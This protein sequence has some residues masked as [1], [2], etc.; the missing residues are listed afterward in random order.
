MIR[1]LTLIVLLGLLTP[2]LTWAS[3]RVL[4]G[5]YPFPP[6]VEGKSGVT[7]DLL[8]AM[9]SAQDKYV[10]E[11][12]ETSAN[13]RY[14]HLEEGKFQLML[15]ESIEW[16][17]DPKLVE[18]SNVFLTGDGDIYMARSA[19]GRDEAYFD[20]I[21]TRKIA[22]T[23]GY[24]YAFAN[25]QTDPE[26]LKKEFDITLVADAKQVVFLVAQ[27]VAEIGVVTK[28]YLQSYLKANPLFASSFLVSKRMDQAY[29]HAVLVKRGSRPTAQEINQILKKL[30][31]S[32]ALQKIWAKHGIVK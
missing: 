9:N 18:A 5:G 8:Q 31:T 13:R 25:F 21:R 14:Q 20:S 28:S 27:G 17:W 11:F 24:H 29:Q 4:V 19:P 22:G 6:F 1:N 10:F 15:F 7:F 30:G 32:G 23:L 16:G 3:Q 2:I 26:I 12:V